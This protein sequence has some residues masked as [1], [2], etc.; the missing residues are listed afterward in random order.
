MDVFDKI[1]TTLKGFFGDAL[2][3]IFSG[4]I[5]I[6]IGFFVVK[7]VK[8][9][10]RRLLT[11]LP[12]NR[13][14]ST[15]LMSILSAVIY[16]IYILIC[17]D[18]FGIPMTGFITL[19]SSIGV[20]VGLALKDSL[21]NIAN[22]ILL[23]VMKPFKVGDFISVNGVEGVVVAIHMIS[24]VVQ[25]TD[26]KVI[27]IPNNEVLADNIINYNGMTTR[28][29]DMNF[30]V[31]YNSD[32]KEVQAVINDILSNHPKILKDPE[33]IC[34]LDEQADSALVFTVKCWVKAEDY[35][36]TKYD[37]NEMTVEAFN[38]HGIEIPYNQLDVNIRKGE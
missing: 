13:T 21:S 30:G 1:I 24:T 38:A 26:N 12:I 16:L 2:F 9:I 33:P 36:N 25:T 10:L 8:F 3:N 29:L 15:F 14:V 23:V 35:W 6:F 11:R 31:S 18:A 5:A 17:A 7:F 32:I 27:T 4:L 28:R 22:G 37:L 20:A 34:R 19:L